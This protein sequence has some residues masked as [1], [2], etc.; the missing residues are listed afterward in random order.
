M[1]EGHEENRERY[2]ELMSASK[3]C[4]AAAGFGFS[5]RVY[6]ASVAG[7]VLILTYRF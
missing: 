7:C 6:E 1:R 4:I 3:F 5:T 2:F